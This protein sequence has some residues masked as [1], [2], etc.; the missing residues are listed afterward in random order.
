M[1]KFFVLLL[2]IIFL[3]TICFAANL[4]SEEDVATFNDMHNNPSNYLAAGGIGTGLS[5]YINKNSIDVQQYAPPNYIIAFTRI[6]YS[7]L[8]DG[9]GSYRKFAQPHLFRY[10]YNIDEQKM[11]Y[12]SERDSKWEYIVPVA[13]G[14]SRSWTSMGEIV[15]Y[16]AYNRSF[17]NEP[18]SVPLNYY[19]ENG[20]WITFEDK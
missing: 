8:P 19:L 18:V 17:Y 9:R 3:P 13:S 1:K 7:V 11:Y 14:P 4:L 6:I 16:L 12:Y 20:K 5:V 2:M 10:K 15:F